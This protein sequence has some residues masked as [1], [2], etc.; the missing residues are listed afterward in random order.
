[1]EKTLYLSEN[2]KLWIKCD[3]P[4]LWIQQPR[5]AGQRV[6]ARL[7][8]RAVVVGNVTLD[9]GSLTLL[10][11]RG[12][13]IALLD[14]RGEPLAMVLGIQDGVQQRRTRQAALSE[15]AEKRERLTAWLDAWERGRQLRLIRTLDPSRARRWRAAGYRRADYD[16]WVLA[17]A[18]MRGCHPRSRTFLTG[19]AHELIAAE[20]TAQG[21]DPHAGVRERGR[22]LGFVKDCYSAL[23]SDIDRI[24][25]TLPDR[26]TEGWLR[27]K[28]RFLAASF[29]SARAHLESLLRLMLEQYAR[30][31]WEI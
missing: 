6:P 30:I 21:W 4:S 10:A 12:V 3:G 5:R 7:V 2:E 19:A 15:D 23:Q 8:R 11:Q 26:S 22:P 16:D 25:L 31:L 27:Q 18:R 1:M 24:W 9:T 14:R 13:P 29:E 28:T 17:Q 20:I